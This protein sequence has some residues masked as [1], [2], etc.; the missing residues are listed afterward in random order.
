MPSQICHCT[1][2]LTIAAIVLCVSSLSPGTVWSHSDVSSFGAAEAA[3]SDE[4]HHHDAA[5]PLPMF[6]ALVQIDPRQVVIVSVR[7]NARVVNLRNLFIGKFVGRGEVL[8]ELE[9]AELET[10][11]RSYSA[12]VSNMAAVEA[13]S[14]TAAERVIGARLDMEWRGMSAED[15][16]RVEMTGQP[17]KTIAVRAPIAGYLYNLNVINNQ[18]L[19]G[20]VQGNQAGIPATVFASIARSDAILV[21]ASVPEKVAAGLAPGRPATVYIVNQ[22]T[23]R[24]PLAA[25]VQQILGFVNALNQ[26]RR[27]RLILNRPPGNMPIV[28]GLAAMVSFPANGVPRV[29]QIKR[30][31]RLVTLPVQTSHSKGLIAV[32]EAKSASPSAWLHTWGQVVA[33]AQDVM[34]VNAYISGEVRRV[35]VRPGEFVRAGTPLI[36]IY[37]P[38]FISTQRGHVALLQNRQKLE[39]LREEGRLPNYMKDAEENLKWWGM[40]AREIAELVKSG[41]VTEEIT[42]AAPADGLVTEVLVQPGTLINAGD[43]TTRSFLV[44]GKSV[45]RLVSNRSPRRVEGY[46]L[47]DQLA[48][49]RRGATVHIEVGGGRVIERRVVQVS[50]TVDPRTQRG[51]F[52][53]DL[54]QSDHKFVLGMSLNLSVRCK[55]EAGIW[56]QREA[57]LA[58]SV[59]PVVYVQIG[60]GRFER[61]PVSVI[62]ESDGL[63][64][65]LGVSSG[66]KV[67]T[68]GKM[69]IEGAFRMSASG[70]AV[71]NL[72]DH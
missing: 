35:F 49:V 19:N 63:I 6:P 22:G 8:G 7:I 53:I 48:L 66:E 56:V 27:V 69:M 65:V 16:T 9:S 36:S 55:P 70:A 68:S 31:I 17:V 32:E 20:A 61:R 58:Q 12:L 29:H 71:G 39:I 41:K 52:F 24:I 28:N 46:L 62:A 4:D 2:R 51:R 59:A 15:I 43:K 10:I 50:P 60:E 45:A 40:T 67:V 54:L 5:V 57:V 11:Q 23:G 25:T 13:A 42:L 18:I 38:E 44:T 34:D 47:P 30:D 72:H 14:V 26:Q 33:N 37:S 21:E 64:Q 3:S 1:I